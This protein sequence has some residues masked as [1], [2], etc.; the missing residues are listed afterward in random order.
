MS[1]I[2]LA[3]VSKVYVMGS[4]EIRALD[5]LDLSIERNEY[6]AIM[7]AS[8][9]GK[10]T[11]MNVVGCL[12]RPTSGSYHLNGTAV[13]DL[14]DDELAQIR[15][16]EIGFVFQTFNLLPRVNCLQNVEL[17]LIYS[18]RKKSQRREMAERAPEGAHRRG[19]E[20]TALRPPRV[21]AP[22]ARAC[23][24]RRPTAA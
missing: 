10:S 9:S 20:S 21:S 3:G 12:D 8:G 16:R 17:P 23:R 24:G 11:L 5:G 14:S 2:E 7:G 6:V 19:P 18:G 22:R 1:L 4:E 13:E 15:N